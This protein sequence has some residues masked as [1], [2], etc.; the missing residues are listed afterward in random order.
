[1]A[2]ITIPAEAPLGACQVRV[3]GPSGV[4]N[5]ISLNIG[6]LPEA[7][8]SNNQ[9]GEGQSVSLPTAIS[10]VIQGPPKA[11]PVPTNAK[12]L[13]RTI[14]AVTGGQDLSHGYKPD[15]DF[16]VR[17]NLTP[18]ARKGLLPKMAI[19]KLGG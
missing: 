3:S 11:V 9:A 13:T 18:L 10:G 4:S 6:H 12:W 5:P 19:K 8:E 2:S 1:M 17:V 15:I 14:A 7:R 16:G